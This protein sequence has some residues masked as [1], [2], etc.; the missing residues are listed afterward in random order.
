MALA[1][2]ITRYRQEVLRQQQATQE[3][4][5]ELDRVKRQLSE[6]EKAAANPPTARSLPSSVPDALPRPSLPAGMPEP[7]MPVPAS[8]LPSPDTAS[9]SSDLRWDGCEQG[10]EAGSA[11]QTGDTWWP[12]VGQSESLE[13]VQ[14]HCRGDAFRNR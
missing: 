9:A 4:K 11:P 3:Q 1:I 7:P 8:P 13:A 6:R 5:A 2:Q 10:G 12:V 14:R